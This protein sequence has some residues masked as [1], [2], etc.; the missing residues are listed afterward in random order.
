MSSGSKSFHQSDK[1][2]ASFISRIS[3]VQESTLKL[4]LVFV[5]MWISQE[6]KTRINIFSLQKKVTQFTTRAALVCWMP[7]LGFLLFFCFPSGRQEKQG[8]QL[9]FWLTSQRAHLT[10]KITSAGRK[11]N[12]DQTLFVYKV[13][14]LCRHFNLYKQWVCL[15]KKQI[16]FFST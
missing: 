13:S 16:H 15:K 11:G 12:Q 3:E 10:R 2:I 4:Q 8:V 14:L 1:I 7:I 6:V 5:V 9:V